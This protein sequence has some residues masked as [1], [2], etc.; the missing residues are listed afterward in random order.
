METVVEF[1]G[2]TY[3]NE[4]VN[5][6]IQFIIDEYSDMYEIAYLDVNDVSQNQLMLQS[7]LTKAFE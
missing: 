3:S 1:T 7:L 4:R 2:Y 5:V 6:K